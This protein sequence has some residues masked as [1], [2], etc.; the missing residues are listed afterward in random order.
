MPN[1]K[2]IRETIA[3]LPS[4]PPLVIALV[5]GT[6][7]IGSYVANALATTF[8][9]QGD[10]LRVYIIGRSAAHAEVV[11]KYGREHSPGSDWRFIQASDV[12]LMSDV[13]RVSQ[14][15][16]QQEEREPFA[17]GPPRL[18]V[19]Y[20]SQ[21]L[22]PLQPSNR[23]FEDS[24]KAGEV[25]IGTP[26]SSTYG[27]TSVRKHVAFMKTFFFEELAAEN[28]GKISFVHIYPGLVD[29]PNFYNADVNPLWFRVVWRIV[30]PL[31]ELAG[32]AYGVGQR[33]DERKDHTM[34]VLN[35]IDN[36]IAAS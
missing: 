25:P 11:I 23:G 29:G 18:D 27:I 9:Q 14:D 20:M 12:S 28:A 26:S 3:T 17:G 6:T 32:G 30:K 19:L 35:G 7:G 15:I 36:K 21:A 4:G 33:G 13:D 2:T 24:I 1:L 22:S 34:E 5:G 31:R 8:S 10:K 16:I